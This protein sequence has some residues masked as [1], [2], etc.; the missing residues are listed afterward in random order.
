[1]GKEFLLGRSHRVRVDGKLSE[2]VR[3]NS[4]VPQGSELGHLLFLSYV[5]DN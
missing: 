2:E 4:C 5:N 1:M 3:V